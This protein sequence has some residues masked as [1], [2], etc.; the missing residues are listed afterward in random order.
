MFRKRILLIDENNK[1]LRGA[2]N[3]AEQDR[4][5]VPWMKPLPI[6]ADGWNMRG[7]SSLTPRKGNPG[8]YPSPYSPS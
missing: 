2:V 5:P 7:A 6:P 8:F 4:R 1:P 3:G